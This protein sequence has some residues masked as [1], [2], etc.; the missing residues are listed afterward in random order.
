MPPK[1]RG[2]KPQVEAFSS[3]MSKCPV[4]KHEILQHTHESVLPILPKLCL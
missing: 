2:H 4:P 1:Q 3:K